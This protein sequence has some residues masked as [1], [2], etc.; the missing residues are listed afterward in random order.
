[1]KE[2]YYDTNRWRDVTCSWTERNNTVKMNIQ[3]KAIYR[4]S[5]IPSKSP[6]AFY[7][8]RTKNFKV[9][10]ETQ[11]NSNSQKNLEKERWS[12]RNQLP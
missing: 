12:W 10:M 6:M 1:M 4:F 11:K 2:I 5:A 8:T 3:S 7:R 9:C